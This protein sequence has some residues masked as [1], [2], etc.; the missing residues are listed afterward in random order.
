[1]G[2]TEGNGGSQNLSFTVHRNSNGGTFSVDYATGSGGSASAGSDFT[3]T[4]G[5][6][7][8]VANGAPSQTIDVPIAGELLVE[9]TETF[10]LVL[11][12]VMNTVGTAA[13]SDG[14]GTG[15]I[16]DN[17][18]ATV[19]FAPATL[20]QSEG[21][22]PMPLTVTLTN[23]VQSGVTLTVNSA[24]G[25]ATAADFTAISG[26]IVTFPPN[27]NTP[28]TVNVTIAND[29]LDEDDEQYTL[30]LSNLTAS[31]N[32]TLPTGSATA[33]ATIQ[34]DDALPVLSV[35]NVSQAEG[36]SG[37]TTM[38]FTVNLTP[39]SGRDVSFTRATADDTAVST[40]SADFV[41]LSAAP[42]TIAAGQT[43]VPVVVTINGDAQFEGDERFFLN[44]SSVTNATPGS[45]IATGTLLDDDQ[46]PTTTTIQSDL[47]DPSLVG[48]P[49]PVDVLVR[50]QTTSPSGTVTISDGSVSCGPVTLSASASPESTASCALASTSAGSKTLTATYTPANTAFAPSSDT[51]AHVV[52]P[53]STTLSVTGPARV[54]INTPASYTIALGVVAPGA[55]AP[56]GAVTVSSGGNA[57]AIILPATSCDLSFSSLGARSI[58]ASYAGDG[59]FQASSSS[60]AST[61]V[62]ALSDVQ[63]SKTDGREVYE[64][65]DLIVYTVQVRNL[66]PDTAETIRLQDTLPAGLSTGQWSCDASGGASCAQNS[67]IGN[68]DQLI[69]LLPRTGVLNYTLF[70]N[71]IGSPTSISNTASLVLP[72]DTIDDPQ[73]ANNSATDLS[74]L[75]RLFA[76]GF[77]APSV[78]APSG[79]F[80]LPG[81]ALRSALDPVAISVY[82]L[83]DSRGPALRV[84]ARLWNGE[85][86]Y[87]LAS[88]D[89]DG[90]LRLNA[91]QRHAGEPTLR[92]TASQNAAGW[93]IQTATLQ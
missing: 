68:L 25:T 55:G 53:A 76:N 81:L 21:T 34:D 43:S 91:W 61:T 90:R 74:I 8:F 46:Q 20:S 82:R 89:G 1:V 85:V 32:V 56:T 31:G 37:T 62:F 92:W 86:E 35:A 78:S 11:S 12:N 44:L 41:A 33:I 48:Q 52:N 22:S 13:I 28:Q 84:Y 19:Q 16:V 51:E 3:A 83:S 58:S 4:S 79:S 15:T 54:R 2:L 5:T 60:D 27:S 59:N 63:V 87:A 42:I 65:G 7:N 71:V 47:P 6:L 10:T 80:V 36:N 77:E 72:P 40:G 75:E 93:V 49:Y 69:P 38:T 18:S 73:A 67:G 30:T 39:L 57:C 29:A 50:A 64:S 45:L 26:A 9:A 88:R 66:G 14:S 23:P 24:T 17:D 70:A